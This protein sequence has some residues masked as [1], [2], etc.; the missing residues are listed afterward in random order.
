MGIHTMNAG[1]LLTHLL[2]QHAAS[3]RQ[4]VLPD[5]S[6]ADRFAFQPIHDKETDAQNAGIFTQPARPRNLHAGVPHD[7]EYLKLLPP[8][9]G[10][11]L[12]DAAPVSTQDQALLTSLRAAHDNRIQR[13]GIAAGAAGETS[14]AAEPNRAPGDLPDID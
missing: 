7:L 10:I 5:N 12:N 3:A 2:G 4:A 8:T 9:E 1:K 13:P 11:G 14:Y 6:P